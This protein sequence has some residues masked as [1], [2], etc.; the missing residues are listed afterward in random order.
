MKKAGAYIR[1]STKDQSNFSIDGQDKNID[2]FA[3]TNNIEIIAKF[4]DD[5]KSAKNF[6]RPEWKKLEAFIKLHY[7]CMDYLIVAK[8]DRFSRNAA[9]GLHKIEMLEKKYGIIILS[10]FEQMYIDYDSPFFFKQRADM[11]VN[12]EFEWHVIR[13]RTR[14]GMHHALSEGRYINRAPFGYKNIKQDKKPLIVID[15]EKA[16]IVKEIF[17]KFMA[18]VPIFEIFRQAKKKGF[19][20]TGRNAITN[21]IKNPV[22]AG[23]VNVPA[24]RKEPS[25]IVKGIHE[26]VVSSFVWWKCQ[27][28]LGKKKGYTIL[29]EAVPFRGLLKCA[30]GL[31][32][33]AGLSSGCRQK[34]WYYKSNHCKLN[35][36]ASKMHL[37]FDEMLQC[38]SL[39]DDHIAF[40]ISEAKALMKQSTLDN[41]RTIAAS[42]AEMTNLREKLTVLEEKFITEQIGADIFHKWEIT[43]K[44]KLDAL[45]SQVKVLENGSKRY[46]QL[47]EEQL[48]KLSSLYSLYNSMDLVDKRIFIKEMFD[49]NL[50]YADGVYRTT[51]LLDLLKHNTMILKEKRLL[52]IDEVTDKSKRLDGSSPYI[53]SIEQNTI[54]FELISKVKTA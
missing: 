26:A 1:I 9:E 21:V 49:N 8:Y 33:T 5:G 2:R 46:W 38:M 29:N 23:M 27:D 14:F 28:L 18:G 11:L 6:D 39:A 7:Q 34:Y 40:L 32:L 12:A 25:K 47:F 30:H 48:P 20:L 10:V 19:K 50:Y 31:P 16:P 41:S 15:E 3:E 35:V 4:V 45:K 36:S 22:Y 52:F 37:Q 54:F 24:Y 44:S 42:K 17:E 43:Y 51:Y 13:D 53:T